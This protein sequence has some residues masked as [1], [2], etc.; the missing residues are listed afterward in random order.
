MNE[1]RMDVDYRRKHAE[2]RLRH[3]KQMLRHA[4][5]VL[6]ALTL[7]GAVD[8]KKY[9]KDHHRNLREISRLQKEEKGVV[10]KIAQSQEALLRARKKYGAFEIK[11]KKKNKK[12]EHDRALLS[13]H[14]QVRS[15]R[16]LAKH[17]KLLGMIKTVNAKYARES[18]IVNGLI[19]KVQK[20]LKRKQRAV[21]A[22]KDLILAQEMSTDLVG[23]Q[24]F[25]E[26]LQNEQDDLQS[27]KSQMQDLQPDLQYNEDQVK[28]L[29]KRL[30][31]Q[32]DK[33]N[34]TSGLQKKALIKE[35]MALL[36]A[37]H[38]LLS[39]RKRE[40]MLRKEIKEAQAALHKS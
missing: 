25:K 18:H 19:L 11:L 34:Q 21:Q 31:Q 23:L 15:R 29:K 8:E 35:K 33:A 28:Q 26:K 37:K 16:V 14:W 1:R 39:E 3:D 30:Q 24:K 20:A 12:W 4:A 17:Q 2:E 38:A 40:K 6:H 7:Q 13:K 32:I 27:S 22:V 5:K 10:E 36:T 9:A